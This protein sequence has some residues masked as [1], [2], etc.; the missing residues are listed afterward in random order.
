MFLNKDGEHAGLEGMYQGRSAALIGGGLS[1]G[2]VDHT[3]IRKSGLLSMAMNN[4]IRS[5]KS[6]LWLGVDASHHFASWLWTD[7]DVMKITPYRHRSRLVVGEPNR[8]VGDCPSTYFYMQTQWFKREQMFAPNDPSIWDN[9]R[10]RG[11]RTSFIDAIRVLFL[12]GI[13]RIFLFGVDFHQ[14]YERPYFHSQNA[15]RRAVMRTNNMYYWSSIRFTRLRPLMEE[16]GLF[17]YNCNPTS[18]LTAFDYISPEE[19]LL[20]ADTSKVSTG[21]PYA[22]SALVSTHRAAPVLKLADRTVNTSTTSQTR[23]AHF[24]PNSFGRIRRAYVVTRHQRRRLLGQL[25]ANI[26]E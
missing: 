10:G 14:T 23:W 25:T 15:S 21:K 24:R 6:D 16:V 7:P 5:Y 9:S 1:F 22:T 17:I 4:A 2:N 11:C 18:K 19:A 12:L 13:R 26:Y 3:A 20:A 8:F